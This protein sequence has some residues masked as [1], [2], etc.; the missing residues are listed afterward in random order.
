MVSMPG[1]VSTVSPAT[2]TVPLFTAS[3]PVPSGYEGTFTFPNAPSIANTAYAG[4]T[5]GATSVPRM[6]VP[7][8]PNSTSS[9]P[10]HQQGATMASLV[11]QMAQLQ[12]QI[13]SMVGALGAGNVNQHFYPGT[14]TGSGPPASL[15][16]HP[17]MTQQATGVPHNIPCH[18]A[19][20]ANTALGHSQQYGVVPPGGHGSLHQEL[21]P[22][23]HYA[24]TPASHQNGMPSVP[25]LK[26]VP[27]S[28]PVQHLCYIKST[29]EKTIRTGLLGE[30]IT[31][32]HFLQNVIVNTDNVNETK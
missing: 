22:T 32:D 1:T 24:S 16:T 28:M 7:S 11:S 8:L 31:L 12:T 17:G 27:P 14:Q 23:T 19:M 13:N 3:N 4:I 25:G 2:G 18:T 30:Y 15:A 10:H 21:Y 5:Y 6:S 20:P 26:P 9:L 29:P